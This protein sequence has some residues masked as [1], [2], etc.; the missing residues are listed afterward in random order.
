MNKG[1]FE[2][3]VAAEALGCSLLSPPR[4]NGYDWLILR[5]VRVR[6]T[7]VCKVLVKP[8]ITFSHSSQTPQNA[9]V[10]RGPGRVRSDVMRRSV[11]LNS[12]R[13][14]MLCHQPR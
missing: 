9:V 10:L 2:S 13:G 11:F 4:R 3:P 7:M 14:S 5:K 8:D 12:C 1:V 6:H